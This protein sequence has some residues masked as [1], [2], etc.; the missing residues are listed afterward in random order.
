MK[1]NF[2]EISDA[3]KDI[4]DGKMI[5]V[6]DNPL[7]ENEGDLVC[8][9]QKVTPKIINFMV[10]FGRGLICAPAKRDIL[11]K[12]N[13]R[14]MVEKSTEKKGCAF[15]VSVDFKE[16]TTTGISAFDR[17]LTIKKLI[18]PSSKSDDFAKPGHIFP[19]AAKDGGVFKRAGHT[20]AAVDL[21]I[22]AGLK[23]AAVICEIM[24][25]DGTMAKIPDLMKFAK[26]HKLK[27]ITV[28]EL[29][30]YRK[31]KE[32]FVAEIVRADFPTRYGHFKI[33]LFKDHISNEEH[34]AI[35]KGNVRG[36]EKVLTRLHSSCATGDIFHSQRCDCGPQLEMALANIEESGEG[37]VL[38]M[39]Q[40]GRGIGLANKLKAYVLQE[41]GLDTVDANIALGFAPDLRDYAACAKILTALGV[42]SVM[43]MTN[44]PKKIKGLQD[45]GLKVEK[46]VAIEIEHTKFN[47][48]YLKTKKNKMGHS[49]KK[50]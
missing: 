28:E 40:E 12:L 19:L 23:P 31:Q 8:A 44:N 7:R 5:I 21:A 27:I 1:N 9:A 6:A 34:L 3:V 41:K 43:L 33:A 35:I 26:K 38:Y 36:K 22:L 37:V 20:E 47:K 14:D 50:I 11:E 2:S 10:K 39:D 16:G 42:K 32:N 4:K 30:K 15:M 13:I 29:I 48:E 46:A 17:A 24:K 25:E 49:L 18:D 45:F